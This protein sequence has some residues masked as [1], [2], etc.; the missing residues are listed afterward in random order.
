[1]EKQYQIG[2]KTFVQKPVVLGQFRLLTPI[3]SGIA[4][5]A[6]ATAAGLVAVLG[7]RLPEALAIVLVEDGANVREAMKDASRAER[8]AE[9]EWTIDPETAVE[10]ISDFF[11][12]N[13]ISSLSEKI[14]GMAGKLTDQLKPKKTVMELNPSSSLSPEATSPEETGSSGEQKS[15]SQSGG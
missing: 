4:I 11:E 10:V 2:G 13:P 5:G 14:T 7:E 6:D 12:C 8:S 9:I 3:V 1:M 15:E